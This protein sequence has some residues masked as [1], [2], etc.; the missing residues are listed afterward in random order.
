[1]GLFQCSFFIA[2]FLLFTRAFA[3]LNV[4]SWTSPTSGDVY[5]PHQTIDCIFQANNLPPSPG[6]RLCIYRDHGVGGANEGSSEEEDSNQRCGTLVYPDIQQ[7]GSEYS[8]TM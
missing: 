8:T 1:M 4:T 2:L 6:F 5:E 3:D 7:N